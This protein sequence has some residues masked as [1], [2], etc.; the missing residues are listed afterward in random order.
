QRLL[1]CL[2]DAKSPDCRYCIL[3]YQ[4][5]KAILM[6][7]SDVDS[8]VNNLLSF[9]IFFPCIFRSICNMYL[10]ES[11]FISIKNFETAS[12]SIRQQPNLE[13][14]QHYIMV[15]M[16]IL[17]TKEQDSYNFSSVM[18][19]YKDIH[20]AFQI[21]VTYYERDRFLM[22]FEQLERRGL[23]SFEDVMGKNPY[24]EIRTLLMS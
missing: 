24:G 14:L 2:L 10:K 7:L 19:E 11:R 6:K 20:D 22:A 17:E 23:I 15:C 21:Y 12:K 1:Y 13:S 5:F 9:L 4:R 18:K 16:K 3:G 8:S